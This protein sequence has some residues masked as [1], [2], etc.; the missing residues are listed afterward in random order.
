MKKAFSLGFLSAVLANPL[1]FLQSLNTVGGTSGLVE[2]P[3]AIDYL[4]VDVV[5]FYMS[6]LSQCH[7][8]TFD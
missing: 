1:G 7:F 4:F 5:V 2:L 3:V 8:E 6:K